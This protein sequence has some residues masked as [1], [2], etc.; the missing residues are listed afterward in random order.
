[1]IVENFS[2]YQPRF[3]A[4][5]RFLGAK[6]GDTVKLYEYIIWVTRKCDEY[7]RMHGLKC[8][9]E[10]DHEKFTE[11]LDVDITKGIRK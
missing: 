10:R 11:W 9:S 7:K 3:R 1:M 4:Y 8:L 2:Q 6:E 5:L